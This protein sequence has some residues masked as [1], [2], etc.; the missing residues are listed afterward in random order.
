MR[1][2]LRKPVTHREEDQQAD[3]QSRKSEGI[4]LFIC[5][6]A[7][8]VQSALRDQPMTGRIVAEGPEQKFCQFPNCVA[9]IVFV[10]PG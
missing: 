5:P 9:T 1:C 8:G 10:K 6:F 7:I 3:R 4:G 2:A